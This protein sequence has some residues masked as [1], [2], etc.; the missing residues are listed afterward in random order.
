LEHAPGDLPAG[1]E[2]LQ[3]AREIGWYPGEA[4]ALL[5]LASALGPRGEY[6][7]GLE[8][9]WQ[10]LTLADEIEHHQWATGSRWAVGAILLDLLA[11]EQ[12]REVLEQGWKLATAIGS[13]HWIGCIAGMLTS[14]YL[15]Q[16]SLAQAEAVLAEALPPGTPFQ[17]IGQRAAW[18][19]RAE[20]ALAQRQPE[21]ALRITEA[22]IAATL[23]AN[24]GWKPLLAARLRGAALAAL[25]RPQEAEG[26]FSSAYQQA[27]EQG[28]RS[29]IWRLGVDLGQCYRAERRHAEAEQCF[30]EARS[31]LES[32]AA[33]VPDDHLR[34]TFLERARA[35]LPPPRPALLRRAQSR[36]Y[37]GLTARELEVARLV[38][39]GKSNRA[40]AGALVV[41]E[42]TAESHVT[43]I[44]IKLNLTSRAQIAAWAIGKGL[45]TPAPDE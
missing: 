16:G 39:E 19:G 29:L 42:R 18:C 21:E 27:K 22:L 2:A 43:N 12:A 35:M 5:V 41:S 36:E 33:G 44:L 23:N 3:I 9:G 14:T 28:W 4:Y 40:I 15:A 10:G 13:R 26:A 8:L 31:E 6:A 32:L 30:T 7:R 34:A 20:L 38:A 45:A 11:L 24:G 37:S 1:E 25:Q 17:S